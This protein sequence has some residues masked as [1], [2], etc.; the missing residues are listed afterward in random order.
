MKEIEF[1]SFKELSRCINDIF[2]TTEPRL[3]KL[4][5][6]FYGTSSHCLPFV[7]NKKKKH[8]ERDNWQV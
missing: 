4:L 5:T 6:K 7:K 3:N 2:I 8:S 1:G